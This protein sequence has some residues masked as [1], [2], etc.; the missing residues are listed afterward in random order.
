MRVVVDFGGMIRDIAI[1]SHALRRRKLDVTDV[2][3]CESDA[4]LSALRCVVEHGM[5]S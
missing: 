5:R 4:C 3:K 2:R 1:T